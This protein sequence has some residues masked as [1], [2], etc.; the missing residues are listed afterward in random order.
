M[1]PVRREIVRRAQA[2]YKAR[3][4]STPEWKA[5]RNS[6]QRAW[7]RKSKENKDDIWHGIVA[8]CRVKNRFVYFI[9]NQHR[10]RHGTKIWA[11]C[12]SLRC[13]CNNI[14]RVPFSDLWSINIIRKMFAAQ[15]RPVQ[16]YV[17]R[18]ELSARKLS[19]IPS[20]PTP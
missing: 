18:L 6:A 11:S 20:T 15:C 7:R 12:V 10:L 14:I 1:T 3:W 2:R 5:K 9:K 19:P 8:R 4:M 13:P 16:C 17:T